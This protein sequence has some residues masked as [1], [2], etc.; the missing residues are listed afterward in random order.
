MLFA[1][2]ISPFCNERFGDSLDFYYSIPFT[3]VLSF[4]C[5]IYALENSPRSV[6]P[7]EATEQLTLLTMTS[8]N[9]MET[10]AAGQGQ[11]EAFTTTSF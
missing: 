7:L 11:Q 3:L 6:P 4:I 1:C 10:T 5:Y 9:I 2:L 8:D